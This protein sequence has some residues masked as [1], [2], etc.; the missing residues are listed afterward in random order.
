M[1]ITGKPKVNV[2]SRAQVQGAA[3]RTILK[4]FGYDAQ[5]HPD[6][7]DPRVYETFGKMVHQYF[8]DSF[9]GNWEGFVDSERD[10]ITNLLADML[11]YTDEVVE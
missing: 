3:F 11:L 10:A 7:Q 9:H 2:V 4:R 8:T 6:K 1:N 5:V